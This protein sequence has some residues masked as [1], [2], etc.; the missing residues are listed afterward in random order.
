MSL[1]VITQTRFTNLDWLEHCKRS[2]AAALPIGAIHKIVPSHEDWAKKRLESVLSDEYVALVDD[3][4]LID[5]RSLSLCV[6]ALE[7]SGAGI[8]FTNEITVDQ[9]LQR[10]TK[11]PDGPKTYDRVR[12]N[13]R[14]LHHIRVFRSSAVDPRALDLHNEFG[15]GID[16]FMVCSAALQHEAIYV[17]IHGY[18][19]RIHSGSETAARNKQW[20]AS[21]A[22]MK[23]RINQT[24]TNRSGLIPRYSLDV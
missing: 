2:V 18:T 10:A 15:M 3:D 14:E 9:Y 20:S 17:P 22:Q 4:D 16:W 12:S 7:E 21:V 24:W 8:A 23:T 19:W 1:T 11:V 13:P 5:P 6:K